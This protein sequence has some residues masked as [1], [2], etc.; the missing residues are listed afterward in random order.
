MQ[1]SVFVTYG[2][3]VDM[4]YVITLFTGAYE[5]IS[6]ANVCMIPYKLFWF[7]TFN[8]A[9]LKKYLKCYKTFLP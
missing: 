3:Y 5:H 7:T 8:L 2:L 1:W 4:I 6:L 9:V